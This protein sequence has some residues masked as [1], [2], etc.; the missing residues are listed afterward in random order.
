MICGLRLPDR[1]NIAV[2]SCVARI[3]WV[4]GKQVVTIE[5]PSKNNDH[6]LQISWQ[7]ID[8][9][10]CGYYQAG[11]KTFYFASSNASEPDSSR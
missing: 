3:K 6:P 10:Q 5:G 8:V 1:S 9:P 4:E 7:E 11:V 2:R